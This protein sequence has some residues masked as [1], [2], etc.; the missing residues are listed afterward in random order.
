MSKTAQRTAARTTKTATNTALSP[1]L[2]IREQL[3]NEGHSG[4]IQTVSLP[5]AVITSLRGILL[6]LDPGLFRDEVLPRKARAAPASFYAEVIRPMLQR[7]PVLAKAE[8]RDSGRGLHAILRFGQ[9]VEFRTE[10][11][12]LRWSR[13]V[14][15]VQRVLPT[16]P[17]CPGLTALTWPLG[18]VNAKSKTAIQLLEAGAPVTADDVLALVEDVR[19]KPFRTVAAILFGPNELQPCPVCQKAEARLDPLDLIGRCYGACGKVKLG[20]LFDVF[21][22]PRK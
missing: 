8:V 9:P 6:D 5:E 12:R 15:V 17:D 10:S 4:P 21:L 22:M 16:D 18:S 2:D 11:D 13:M 3:V 20:Q 1:M 7:H 14:R 19:T